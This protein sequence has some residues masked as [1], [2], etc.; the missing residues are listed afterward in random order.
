MMQLSLISMIAALI[1]VGCTSINVQPVG[2]GINI[3]DVCIEE[4]SKVI[5]SDFLTVVRDGFDRHGIAT[6]VVIRPAPPE[7]EY[8]LTYTALKTWDFGTYLHHAELR[9]EKNGRL[10]GSAE[11]HL[12]GKGGLSL[13]KWQNT[14]TKMDPVIDQLLFNVRAN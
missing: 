5:V 4:N 6:K 9:I 1:C 10:I 2:A 3:V 12:T 14:K 11:Y 8:V 13:T 7:C